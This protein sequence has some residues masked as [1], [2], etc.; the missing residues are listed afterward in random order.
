M[1]WIAREIN[2]MDNTVE[3]EL[4]ST[5]ALVFPG[6]TQLFNKFKADILINKDRDMPELFPYLA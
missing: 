5:T 6:T 4:Y 1:P 2:D 3:P